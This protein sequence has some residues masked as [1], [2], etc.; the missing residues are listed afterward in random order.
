MSPLSKVRLVDIPTISDSRGRLSVLEQGAGVPF[1]IR[2]VFFM[3]HMEA[4]RGG[5]A[6]RDTEQVVLAAA[7]SFRITLTDAKS[8]LTYVLDDPS[9]GVYMPPMVY[10]TLTDFSPGAVCLVLAST[11]YDMSRSIRT[12]EDFLRE[13]TP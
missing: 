9:R 5:H 4:D 13:M 6:H 7:G 12:Y 11:I 10:V 3:H 2:R 1:E 8:S